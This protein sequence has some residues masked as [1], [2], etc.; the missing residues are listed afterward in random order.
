[1]IGDSLMAAPILYE[2]TFNR[3]VYLPS[4]EWYD[5]HSGEVIDSRV[6]NISNYYNDLVPLY[7][8]PGK[9]IAV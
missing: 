2:N 8:R 3:S 9:V 5:Y 7:F 4:S 6:I 1:M